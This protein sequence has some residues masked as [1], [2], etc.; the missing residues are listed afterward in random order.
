MIKLN[1]IIKFPKVPQ[2]IYET[3]MKI[4]TEYTMGGQQEYV[5][6]RELAKIFAYNVMHNWDSIVSAVKDSRFNRPTFRIVSDILSIDP[7][8]G[9]KVIN[10]TT[11]RNW[12]N[13]LRS[14][15][16]LQTKLIPLVPEIETEAEDESSEPEM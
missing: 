1:D 5:N 11:V 7:I 2:D 4:R 14:C 6:Q 8:S 12:I 16:P 9:K 15:M 13:E 10:F 3:Y